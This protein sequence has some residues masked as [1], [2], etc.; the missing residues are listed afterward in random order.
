M[1]TILERVNLNRAFKEV[2]ANKGSAGV[3]G[4]KVDDLLDYLRSNGAELVQ[5]I[6]EGRYEPSPVRRVFI[7][8]ENGQKRPLGIPTVVD[9]FVQQ[10]VGRVRSLQY[11]LVFSDN[12]HGFR[13][14]RSC[15]TASTA[16]A[17][18][19]YWGSLR[20]RANS[21]SFKGLER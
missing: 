10:A 7:P 13:P 14:A 5:S 12:S 18:P 15:S 1:E 2:V 17:R 11:E 16:L 19:T 21:D 9:R 6:K 8:K 20:L 3:D 4:M